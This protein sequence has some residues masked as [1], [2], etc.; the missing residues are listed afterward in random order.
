MDTPP[1]L[2]GHGA[3]RP[4]AGGAAETVTTCAFR[5]VIADG[6]E[7]D[8][9]SMEEHM[10]Y[11]IVRCTWPKDGIDELIQPREHKVLNSHESCYEAEQQAEALV[12]KFAYHRFDR[13][14]ECWKVQDGARH[15]FTILVERV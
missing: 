10:P 5:V 12:A 8:A 13:E 4:A 6:W 7:R 3:S 15:T 14:Q 11:R 2:G 9:T 1:W